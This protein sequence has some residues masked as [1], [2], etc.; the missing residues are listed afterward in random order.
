MTSPGVTRV[1]HSAR[2]TMEPGSALAARRVFR[3]VILTLFGIVAGLD[4]LLLGGLEIVSATRAYVGGE[5]MWAKGQKD[6]IAALLRYTESGD[7]ADYARYERAIAIPLGDRRARIALEQ[8]EFDSAVAREGLIAGGNHPDDVTR[9]IRL[10]R[11]GWWE[12]HV[13]RALDIWAQGD[14]DIA[15]TTELAERL[16]VE[17]SGSRSPE[18]IAAITRDL[19]AVNEHVTPLELAF[20]R[21]L[22]NAARQVQLTSAIVV[23]LSSLVLLG[24]GAT[25]LG[26]LL[27]EIDR[28][29]ERALQQRVAQD[30]HPERL[31][32]RRDDHGRR[33]ADRRV[34]PVGGTDVRSDARRSNR[35]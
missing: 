28:Y 22:G 34:Q 15:R 29:D 12:P 8:R 33:R 31:A 27:A 6:S 24:A 13:A 7:P 32:R 25:M 3:P 14:L 23:I 10:V 17:M 18:R 20:S 21:T 5:S 16:R 35:P 19:R 2:F 9:M 11:W 30:R 26:R 4:L 1:V